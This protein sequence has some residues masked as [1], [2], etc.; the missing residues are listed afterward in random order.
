M[1]QKNIAICYFVYNN[2]VNF[3]SESLR[4]LELVIDRH[5]EYNIQTFV[6]G[7]ISKIKFRH[8]I[9]FIKNKL[10]KNTKYEQFND[11]FLQ[12]KKLQDIF[13]YDFLIKADGL[14]CINSLDYFYILEENLKFLGIDYSSLSYFTNF[15]GKDYPCPFWQNFTKNGINIIYDICQLANTEKH[16][17][18]KN[19]INSEY[20]E[21]VIIN[22]L[23]K[24]SLTLV[25]NTDNIFNLK[26][27]CN[28]F[29]K[30]VENYLEYSAISFRDISKQPNLE[31]SFKE[32]LNY[33]NSLL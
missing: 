23:L 19:F 7:D 9:I 29:I 2:E 11:I 6:I 33:I 4:C 20:P 26:G 24:K 13:Q 5:P 31:L 15:I 30:M 16:K 22:V 1:K 8:P 10:Q 14:T 32:M 18:I 28:P 25:I 21:S 27:C 3:L 12:L 17:D